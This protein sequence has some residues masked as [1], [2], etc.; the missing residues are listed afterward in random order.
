MILFDILKKV[1]LYNL[2]FNNVVM[3]YRY[4]N[5][6]FFFNQINLFVDFASN[7]TILYFL[8]DIFR[9]VL[10]PTLILMWILHDSTKDNNL[11][12]PVNLTLSTYPDAT[13]FMTNNTHKSRLYNATVEYTEMHGGSVLYSNNSYIVEGEYYVPP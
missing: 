4:V 11:E 9:Q 8:L 5:S 2:A 13:V 10:L 12:R 6:T 1:D 3:S 7:F